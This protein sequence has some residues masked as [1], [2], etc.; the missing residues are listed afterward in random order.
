MFSDENEFHGNSAAILWEIHGSA[1]YLIFNK[2]HPFDKKFN[3]QQN[4]QYSMTKINSTAIKRLFNGN[5]KTIQRQ[6]NII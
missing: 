2:K 1:E 3:I 6:H 4:I 5:S